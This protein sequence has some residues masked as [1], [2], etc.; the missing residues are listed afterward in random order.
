MKCDLFKFF[1]S[2]CIYARASVCAS[3]CE[4][5][6]IKMRYT[7]VI[8][9]YRVCI[10][11]T[12]NC[13]WYLRN[14]RAAEWKMVAKDKLL[15]CY[16]SQRKIKPFYDHKV[17]TMKSIYRTP[18]Q[19][20]L[21]VSILIRSLITL[22]LFPFFFFLTLADECEFF[23]PSVHSFVCDHF[24]ITAYVATCHS[25]RSRY[26]LLE[27][28]FWLKIL[29]VQHYALSMKPFWSSIKLNVRSE[30]VDEINEAITRKF[31]LMPIELYDSQYILRIF[32]KAQMNV[33]RFATMWHPIGR[34]SH[35]MKTHTLTHTKIRIE[36]Q[37]IR[38]VDVWHLK[39]IGRRSTQD[40]GW[41]LTIFQ[42][43]EWIDVIDCWKIIR[44]IQI[45]RKYR[46]ISEAPNQVKLN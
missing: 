20:Q 14:N 16:R 18:K 12:P 31:L 8:P 33:D 26:L 43:R 32:C 23:P 46:E 45:L 3:V 13:Q 25:H 28:N 27:L 37:H 21:S 36:C 15:F 10:Y 1:F 44:I 6:I 7:A 4:V 35:W 42:L 19:N 22:F 30:T 29:S 41:H 40:C 2:F 34:Y 11:N 5:H 38:M 17:M 9:I 24:S 39:S